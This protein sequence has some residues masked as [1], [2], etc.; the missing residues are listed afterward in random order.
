MK[1]VTL[2]LIVMAVFSFSCNKQNQ[3]S[4]YESITPALLE[5]NKFIQNGKEWDDIQNAYAAALHKIA[6]NK[7]TVDA[8]IRLAEI[9]INEARVTGEHGHYYPGALKVLEKGLQID[10]ITEDQKFSILSYKASV[11]LS[12]HEFSFAL[13]IGKEAQLLNPYNAQI[14]GVLVD[15]FVELGDYGNAVLMADKMISIRPDLRSYS[16]VSYLR[17]IHGDLA[18]AIE[19]MQLAVTAGLPGDEQTAW[20]RLTLGAL[21][22]KN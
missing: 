1:S 18:G 17:E 9:F 15:A 2:V 10:K 3:Y 12:Q 8:Y 7:N 11:L 5:R 16:R 22:E 4:K 19:A 14:Y 21:F 20:A 13:T 6:K